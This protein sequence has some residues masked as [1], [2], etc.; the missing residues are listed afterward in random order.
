[1][2]SSIEPAKII[3][4]FCSFA[5]ED[6]PLQ[7]KLEKQLKSLERQGQ[8]FVWDKHKVHPGQE[9]KREIENQL[10]EADLILLLISQ[11][12]IS[13]DDCYGIELGKALRRYAD[14]K[15]RIVPILLRPCTWN[16]LRFSTFQV[17]P[18][19][20]KPVTLW[21]KQ[22]VAFQQ[23]V[24]EIETI[25]REIRQHGHGYIEPLQMKQ[26]SSIRNKE[27]K[28]STTSQR[29]NATKRS[30]RPTVKTE[31]RTLKDVHGVSANRRYPKALPKGR[32]ISSG[33]TIL[34]FF[35]FI[36]NNL[37]SKAFTKRCKSYSA[38]LLFL[39]AILDVALLPYAV[40][41]WIHSLIL[42]GA[43]FCVSLALFIMGVYNT[44]NAIGVPI[45]F[46]Y[47][48]LWVVVDI[49]F[50]LSYF[51]WRWSLLTIVMF[52]AIIPSLRLIL[53]LKRK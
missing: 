44:D 41:L 33:Y 21:S 49:E 28:I 25:V 53:F 12:F 10:K 19:N 13:S 14:G 27:E 32:T 47:F 40:Y 4:V 2:S 11:N 50:L 46:I 6:Q 35:R 31:Q 43:F 18:R 30:T 9:Q 38:V 37:S 5:D 52:I 17:L 29:A 16:G 1:M 26:T 39:F 15:A 7:K 3:R 48:L 36:S 23:I 51:K 34:S 8:V 24:Q 42:L 22:D 20:E 45:A